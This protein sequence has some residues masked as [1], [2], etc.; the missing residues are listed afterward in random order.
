MTTNEESMFETGRRSGEVIAM[1][2]AVEAAT[3]VM[4]KLREEWAKAAVGTKESSL[5]MARMA[6]AADVLDALSEVTAG[7]P[8]DEAVAKVSGA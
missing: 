8:I 1:M 5:A 3:L 7:A 2:R 4:G 6:G